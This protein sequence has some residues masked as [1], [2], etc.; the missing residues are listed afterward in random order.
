[1]LNPKVHYYLIKFL[2]TLTKQDT[3]PDLIK[4]KIFDESDLKKLRGYAHRLMAYDYSVF[5]RL[6]DQRLKGLRVWE[7]GLLLDFL[8]SSPNAQHWNVLDVGPGRSVLP[9][10]IAE[11]TQSVT[12]IDYESPLERPTE[13]S[14]AKWE[15]LKI[16]SNQGSMLELPYENEKFDL[17]TCIS[18]IEHLDDLGNG[19]Q[20]PYEE[21]IEKTKV[22]LAEMARVVKKGGHLYLTTDAYIPEMQK[23]IDIWSR[24]RKP[25]NIIWS[26]F[27]YN[28][29]QEVFV[30]ILEKSG[31]KLVG[32]P[33]YDKDLLLT[34]PGRSSYRGRYFTTF[35]LLAQK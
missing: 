33:E 22:G 25:G 26:A 3:V 28:E 16:T 14:K 32:K 23:D 35:T 19:K 20:L 4:C 13:Y 1:M 6:T 12:T 9:A 29:I 30:E 15:K 7:Y 8:K 11:I 34:N 24:K 31:L 17:V 2:A 21:F 18:V 27:K 10:F 5:Q